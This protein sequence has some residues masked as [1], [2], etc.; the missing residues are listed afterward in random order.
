[1]PTGLLFLAE[2]CRA[3][4][5]EALAFS[6]ILSN[7]ESCSTVVKAYAVVWS[8]GAGVE[9]Y[10][11]LGRH[12]RGGQAVRIGTNPILLELNV[13]GLAAGAYL[14]RVTERDRVAEGRVVVRY[15]NP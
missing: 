14:V 15:A 8:D 12:V 3:G 11:V 9:I 2:S 7:A 5:R 4:E 10:D 13:A 1:M 6:A